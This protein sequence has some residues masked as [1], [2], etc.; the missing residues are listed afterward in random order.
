MGEII[1]RAPGPGLCPL[2]ATRHGAGAPCDV[3]SLYY[4]VRY[5]KRNGRFPVRD[6]AD[7][8]GAHGTDSQH[9]RE[10]PEHD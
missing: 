1:V 7:E 5:Y 9:Q 4:M 2:C 8:G 10:E 6:D 3:R